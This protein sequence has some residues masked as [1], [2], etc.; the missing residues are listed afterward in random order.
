MAI[1]TLKTK[2]KVTVNPRAVQEE[3][4]YMD[5]L[6]VIYNGEWYTGRLE[7]YYKAPAGTGTFEEVTDPVTEEVTQ[8]EIMGTKNV[9][10]EETLSNFTRSEANAITL[11]M[12][13]LPSTTD[14]SINFDQLIYAGVMYQ[15]SVAP[16]Y[17]LSVSGWEIVS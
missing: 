9:L 11:G 14:H 17:G 1:L 5:I 7:Y 16:Y 10:L 6:D 2:T 3:Y 4:V 15:L 13:G 12:G 8:V